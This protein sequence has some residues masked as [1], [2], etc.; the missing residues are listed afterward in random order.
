MSDRDPTNGLLAAI[1]AEAGSP[2][3]EWARAPV[4]LTGGFWAELW[5]VELA[6]DEPVL[7]GDLVARVMPDPEVAARETAVQAH[8]AERGYPTPAV[9][10]HGAPGPELDRAWMLMDH[11]R[12]LPMIDDLSG[13]GAIA[14]LPRLARAM[15]DQLARCAAGLHT[16]DPGPLRSTLL[17]AD[18]LP[19]LHALAGTLDRPDLVAV[20]DWLE[21]TR[22]AAGAMV[23]C[24]GDLHPFNVLTHTDG[25]TVLDWSSAI[26]AEPESDLAFTHLL[27]ANPPLVAPPPLRPAIA[28]AGRALARRFVRTYERLAGAPVP[29]DRLGWYV[30]LHALRVVAE[31]A[32]WQADDSPD[33]RPGHPY[34]LLAPTL[35]RRL[36]ARIAA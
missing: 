26:I 5:R 6:T 8:L 27:L 36:R 18:P 16:L 4:P 30:D 12:G 14:R 28:A 7:G 11:A 17:D 35:S 10:L 22:P 9:R 25:D 2:S 3:L 1:R 21:H 23:F 20:A 13:I 33:R 29:P 15:P 24:H 19:R 32:S 34:H 31:V